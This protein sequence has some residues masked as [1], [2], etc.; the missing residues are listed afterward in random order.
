VYYVTSV[1]PAGLDGTKYG[2]EK[3][4]EK[5]KHVE[6]WPGHDN[7]LSHHFFFASSVRNGLPD[8]RLS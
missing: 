3:E 1:Q 2:K 8:Y 4:Q 6:T 5:E 7:A